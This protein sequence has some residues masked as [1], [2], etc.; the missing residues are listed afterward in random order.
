MTTQAI[1]DELNHRKW[2]QKGDGSAITAF[3]IHGR[4]KNYSNLFV[5]NGSLVSLVRSETYLPLPKKVPAKKSSTKEE[6]KTKDEDYVLDLCDEVLNRVASRQHRFDFLLGDVNAK[7]FAA[8]LPVDAYYE[9]LKLVIEYREQQHTEAVSFFDKPDR[10]TV[11]GVHRG[12][13][14]KIYDE[15][16]RVL[17]PQNGLA[18]VEISYTDFSYNSRKRIVRNYSHDVDVVRRMLKNYS[19]R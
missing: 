8:K 17:I 12:G 13:Q 11:S 4:T 5:R 1:A 7:G 6:T 14:R 9:D 2:Y 10:I 16:R 19:G 3:Q 18:L 15:R